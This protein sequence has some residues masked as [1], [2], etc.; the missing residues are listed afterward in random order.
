VSAR[1]LALVAVLAA[2]I[3]AGIAEARYES[4]RAVWRA[5]SDLESAGYDRSASDAAYR[6]V[7]DA[8][9]WVERLSRGAALVIAVAALAAGRGTGVPHPGLLPAG[10]EREEGAGARLA[11]AV[12]ALVIAMGAS[13]WLVPFSSPGLALTAR[14]LWLGTCVALTA[15][16][17]ARRTSLAALF[18]DPFRRR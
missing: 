9:T 14:W 5:V 6:E 16:A 2:A 1:R 17:R 13:L 15:N 4:A 8:L 10:R 3:G 12:D 11:L 18:V 7:E